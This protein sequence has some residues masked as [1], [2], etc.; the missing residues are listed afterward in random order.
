MVKKNQAFQI[1]KNLLNV[2][3]YSKKKNYKINNT[4]LPNLKKN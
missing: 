1:V 2:I 3:K 4:K